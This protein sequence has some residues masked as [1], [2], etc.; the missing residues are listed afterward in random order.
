MHAPSLITPAHS[1]ADRIR[2]L[3]I[4][5]LANPDWVSVPLEGWSNWHALSK[6]VDGH[7]VTHVRNKENI[8]N[9]GESPER[10]TIIDS[11]PVERP[12]AR[13]ANVLRGRSEGGLT[14]LTAVST[15]PYYY[16][17]HVLWRTLGP[18][19][20]SREWDIVHRVTPLTPTTPSLLA[21]RCAQH[22]IPFVVGPLNGGVPWPKGFDHARNAEREW[23][24][25]VR[26]AYKILPG[27]RI[28]RRCASAIITGS[29]D[30]RMQIA[31]QY[32]D[33]TVYIPENAVDPKR[34]TE[35]KTEPITLPLKVAFVGRLT[36]YK[37]P[38][39]LIEAAAPLAREGRLTLDII[40]DGPQ[41]PAL[42]A[43]AAREGLPESMFAGWIQHDKLQQR[44]AKSDIFAFPSIREFGGAVVLEAMALGLVPVV[45]AYGG[46]GE[47]VTPSTGF[48]LPMGSRRE[49]VAS[50]RAVLERLT[51][52]PSAIRSMGE[53]ARARVLRS[54][55]WDAKAAQVLEVYRWVLGQRDKPDFG[56]PLPDPP[57]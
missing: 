43:L 9:A 38:D 14:T 42:R 46:P 21:A 12:M 51:A 18:R 31:R 19:I 41:A 40:G 24:T 53:R 57:A 47:L 44:L 6:I 30:T 2:V 56:M 13:V 37:G 36:L 28:T 26:E 33:K 32:R 49:I 10:V 23:L 16:F 52:D 3:I 11:S 27:Y 1:V 39:M 4:A 20:K 15:F 35:R 22:G 54:F 7:L 29:G 50:L 25:Y 8:L 45:M 17:E 55:T 34:F 48:T 5:E